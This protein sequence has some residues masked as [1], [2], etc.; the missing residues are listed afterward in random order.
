[1]GS[2]ILPGICYS[3]TSP[4]TE[5]FCNDKL[6]FFTRDCLRGHRLT[7]PRFS[8]LWNGRSFLLG[9]GRGKE[10]TKSDIDEKLYRDDRNWTGLNR[11][12]D[13]AT[14][15][16]KALRALWF[17]RVR[18]APFFIGPT[19]LHPS[20][21]NRGPWALKSRASGVRMSLIQSLVGFEC[22]HDGTERGGPEFGRRQ[23]GVER[24]SGDFFASR[25]SGRS[26]EGFVVR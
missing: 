7:S 19:R 24:L 10:R 11:S 18:I 25:A 2:I 9:K 1:M 4:A 13:S 5:I 17:S 8:G 20:R 6:S 15:E 12:R 23:I 21:Q 16:S 22:G 3:S 26:E 14:G